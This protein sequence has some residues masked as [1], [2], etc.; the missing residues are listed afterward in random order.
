[1][2]V[3][4]VGRFLVPARFISKLTKHVSLRGESDQYEYLGKVSS[5]LQWSH[6]TGVKIHVG[7]NR[8]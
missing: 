6:R 8:E 7:F 4:F 1:M 5:T 2:G 3:Y